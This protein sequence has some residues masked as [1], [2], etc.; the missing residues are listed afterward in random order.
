MREYKPTLQH[1]LEYAIA[2]LI[3]WTVRRLSWSASYKFGSKLGDLVY[4]LK[5]ERRVAMEGLRQAFGGEKTEKELTAIAREAY[6]NFG[7][8]VVEF[9]R[10]PLLNRDNIDDFIKIEGLENLERA[11]SLGRGVIAVVGHLG[12]WEWL[13]AAIS[14]K[15]YPLHAI[16]RLQDNRLIDREINSMRRGTG[17]VIIPRG[18][19]I[20]DAIRCLKNKAPLGMFIDQNWA[21]NGIFV[22]FFGK[23]AATAKG[24]ALLALKL[25]CPVLT[26]YIYRDEN[27]KHTV[28]I[29]G[30][31]ELIRTGD[32]ER[33]VW[34]NTQLFT[35]IYEGYI[36]KHPEQWFWLHPRWRKRPPGE[37]R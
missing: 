29:E 28:V 21:V 16:A 3:L 32:M 37:E 13:G 23:L 18:I 20:R 5:L 33:D 8:C 14:I 7:K 2:K 19:E 31:H 26:S 4:H 34:E 25:G 24:P 6:R 27:N 1:R 35:K 9:M 11:L 30:P 15:G 36:R 10:M 17:M 12:N 22:D